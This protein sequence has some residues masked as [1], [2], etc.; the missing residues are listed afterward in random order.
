MAKLFVQVSNCFVLRP[1]PVG[2]GSSAE[3]TLLR[4]PG[5]RCPVGGEQYNAPEGSVVTYDAG[6]V[7]YS[8]GKCN[9]RPLAPL[10]LPS[11]FPASSR[12]LPTP[13]QTC[14]K[15]GSDGEKEQA[16]TTLLHPF[17]LPPFLPPSLPPSL[18]SSFPRCER[19]LV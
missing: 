14:C 10:P 4:Q 13:S 2:R 17:S 12:P 8:R 11:S 6:R 18:P 9:G 15:C 5:E 1:A 7:M 16:K 19:C 3:N